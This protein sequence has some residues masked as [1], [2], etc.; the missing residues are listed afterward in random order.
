MYI[1]YDVIE[2]CSGLGKWIGRVNICSVKDPGPVPVSPLVTV[3]SGYLG[4]YSSHL[5]Y[6]VRD[7]GS[8]LVSL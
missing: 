4:W 2:Y 5:Q 8:V 1:Y 7:P 6:S 3:Q